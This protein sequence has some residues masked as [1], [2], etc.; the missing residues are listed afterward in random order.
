MMDSGIELIGALVVV[1]IVLISISIYIGK[2]LGA[3]LIY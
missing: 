3:S 1:T 2:N